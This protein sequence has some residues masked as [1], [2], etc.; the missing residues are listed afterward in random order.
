MQGQYHETVNL[1]RAN[2]RNP[3]SK[4]RSRFIF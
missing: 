1:H 2:L 4:L 3:F